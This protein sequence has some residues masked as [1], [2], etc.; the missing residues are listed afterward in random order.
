VG[1]AFIGD[2]AWVGASVQPRTTVSGDPFAHMTLPINRVRPRRQVA[3]GA[4]I[5]APPAA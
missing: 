1:P 4:R 3:N 5:D 2:R